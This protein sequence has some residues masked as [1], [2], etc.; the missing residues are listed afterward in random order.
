M[1]MGVSTTAIKPTGRLLMYENECE[2]CTAPGTVQDNGL[3]LCRTC[4]LLAETE[5]EGEFFWNT[6]SEVSHE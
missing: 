3:T 1:P 2:M 5:P 4:S 6:L